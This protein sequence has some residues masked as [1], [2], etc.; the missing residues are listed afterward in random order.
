MHDR[1]VS[2]PSFAYEI[3]FYD[4]YSRQRAGTGW[5]ALF[6]YDVPLRSVDAGARC[7]DIWF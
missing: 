5:M 3:S 6:P 4:Q 7:L 1:F 2:L